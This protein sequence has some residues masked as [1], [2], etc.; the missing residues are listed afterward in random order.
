MAKKEPKTYTVY[1]RPFKGEPGA[2]LTVIANYV[3]VNGRGDLVFSNTSSV[4]GGTNVACFATGS[5]LRCDCQNVT[6]Q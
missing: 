5:W 2:T 6:E 4:Y 1:M 3:S